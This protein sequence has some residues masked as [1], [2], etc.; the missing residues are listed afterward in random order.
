MHVHQHSAI[1]H[2]FGQYIYNSVS[3]NFKLLLF[4]IWSIAFNGNTQKQTI[5]GKEEERARARTYVLSHC[6]ILHYNSAHANVL[7]HMNACFFEL[8]NYEQH[9]SYVCWFAHVPF[10]IYVRIQCVPVMCVRFWWAVL[11]RFH[12]NMRLR[13]HRAH[14]MHWNWMLLWF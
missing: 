12:T 11:M 10:F 8:M 1:W 3:N 7:G 2:F 6:N 14:S 5:W 4:P 13:R 9:Y